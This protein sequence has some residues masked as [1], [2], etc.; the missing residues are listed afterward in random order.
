MK[1]FLLAFAI[2]GLSG[3]ST[4]SDL[5]PFPAPFDPVE[6][7]YL[8]DARFLTTKVYA[9]CGTDDTPGYAHGVLEQIQRAQI[10]SKYIPSN[11]EVIDAEGI[12][13]KL[14]TELTTRIDSK[15]YSVTYCHLKANEIGS[16][17]DDLNKVL[18]EKKR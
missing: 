4:L 10:Y 3:C 1:R 7:G 13:I 15:S 5:N 2:L 6:L 14:S 17:L 9:S 16:A 8:A 18:G 12:L 11:K